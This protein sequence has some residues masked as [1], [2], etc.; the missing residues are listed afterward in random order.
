MSRAKAATP[1]KI[2]YLLVL[3]L[4]TSL[5]LTAFLHELGADSAV[6]LM[7]IPL[8]LN[9]ESPREIR[10]SSHW[11]IPNRVL[12][13]EYPYSQRYIDILLETCKVNTFVNLLRNESL[14]YFKLSPYEFE[15]PNYVKVFSFPIFDRKWPED[16]KVIQF[17]SDLVYHFIFAK[18]S[19][20][21]IH[22]LGGHG[23]TGLI[24]A[25]FL[26]AYYK[27][28]ATYSL[29]KLN[30]F[31]KARRKY[32]LLGESHF[33]NK[34][35]RNNRTNYFLPETKK[36]V[37]QVHRLENSMHGLMETII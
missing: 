22:C 2:T 15:M 19:I 9:M 8:L 3:C 23:R 35:E 34:C 4:L 28:N 33:E 5:V 7:S 25:L 13:G 26:E 17:I 29:E 30:E 20:I 11:I 6:N 16:G 27:W 24:S 18:D 1:S 12:I 10:G 21:Y 31:H 37:L 36:Q 14:A 32:E